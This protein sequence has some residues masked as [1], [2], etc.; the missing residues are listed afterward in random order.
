V[1]EEA[2]YENATSHQSH[3]SRNSQLDLA[4][5]DHFE[6]V[7]DHPNSLSAPDIEMPFATAEKR[8]TSNKEKPSPVKFKDQ[9]EE[10][11]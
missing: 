3:L 11:V 6:G 10:E 4:E 7:D 2:E 5:Q 9:I 8:S 1:I